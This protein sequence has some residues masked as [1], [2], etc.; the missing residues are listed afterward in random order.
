MNI[1][2]APWVGSLHASANRAVEE[3]LQESGKKLRALCR[4]PE[5]RLTN[6]H[7]AHTRGTCKRRCCGSERNPTRSSHSR[8]PSPV[9]H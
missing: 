2:Q 8:P 6:V 7:E 9:P 1:T 3:L 4:L 5:V